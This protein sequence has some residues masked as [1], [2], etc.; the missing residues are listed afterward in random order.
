MALPLNKISSE[1]LVSELVESESSKVIGKVSDRIT[2]MTDRRLRS[3]G[4]DYG[5]LFILTTLNFLH[6]DYFDP[7][8]IEIGPVVLENVFLIV[9][10]FLYFVIISRI[11][12]VLSFKQT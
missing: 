6:K 3:R 1:C 12:R 10:L 7:K 5:Q 4:Y 9:S 2:E 8:I 11:K